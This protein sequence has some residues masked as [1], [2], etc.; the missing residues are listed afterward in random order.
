M[1]SGPCVAE[2]VEPRR[3]ERRLARRWLPPALD[4]H[5]KQGFSVPLDTWF[6]QAG[7][8]LPRVLQRPYGSFSCDEPR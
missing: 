3:I 1:R 7:P 2:R 4:S 6:R 5:R 8:E